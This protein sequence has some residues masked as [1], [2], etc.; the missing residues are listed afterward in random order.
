V[1]F[2]ATKDELRRL[3][4]TLSDAEASA[5]LDYAHWLTEECDTLTPDELARVHEGEAQIR[6]GEYVTL[7]ALNRALER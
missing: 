6:R 5:L 2:V 7:N 3:V 4:D 1:T